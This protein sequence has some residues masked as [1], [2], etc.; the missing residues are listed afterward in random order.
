MTPGVIAQTRT[1]YASY[2]K[3]WKDTFDA[4]VARPDRPLSAKDQNR[5]DV[6]RIHYEIFQIR[7]A[8]GTS[9]RERNYDRFNPAFDHIIKLIEGL[10]D[11][12]RYGISSHDVLP[13]LSLDMGVIAP[14]YFTAIKCRDHDTRQKAIDLLDR[15]PCREGVWDQR[16]LAK[17]ARKAMEIEESGTVRRNGAK[18]IRDAARIHRID[19][20]FLGTPKTLKASLHR[21]VDE[22]PI[23][24]MIL[25]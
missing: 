16:A 12:F 15:W 21:G 2:L 19:I 20:E 9:T 1:K 8:F 13:M 22:E 7:L 3:A 17:L 11:P 25:W 24:E 4:F 5:A 23:E 18:V 6:L 14:L 10:I